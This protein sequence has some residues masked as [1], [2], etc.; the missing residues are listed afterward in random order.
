M[1]KRNSTNIG[2]EPWR[3]K[4]SSRLMT[5]I[6][7]KSI[8]DSAKILRDKVLLKRDSGKNLYLEL[9]NT[10]EW[11][12]ILSKSPTKSPLRGNTQTAMMWPSWSMVCRSCKWNWNAAAL[13]W[14]KHSTK[15]CVTGN[16]PSPDFFRYIQ[17]FVISNSQERAISPT[18]MEKPEESHVLLVRRG[19]TTASMYWVNLRKASWRNAIWQKW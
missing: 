7:G 4:N 1:E 5:Q 2:E 14:R 17:V 11:C 3:I 12:K 15:S 8:F 13:T 19:A 10:K 9:F 6:N 16:T 18:V